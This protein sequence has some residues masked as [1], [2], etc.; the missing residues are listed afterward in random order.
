MQP[1]EG[2]AEGDLDST[3]RGSAARKNEGKDPMELIPVRMWIAWWSA[4]YDVDSSSDLIQFLIVLADWQERNGDI[5][6]AWHR[7]PPKYRED[8]LKVLEFGAKKYKAWNWAKGQRW[9]CTLGSLLR[10]CRALLQGEGY[11][12]DSGLHHWGHIGCN[13]LFL[14]WFREHYMDGDDRPPI[15]DAEGNLK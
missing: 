8:V 14:F 11:D 1:E 6:L 2:V 10:H 3:E 9:G 5:A 4:M 7:I 13:T 12:E 15:Y